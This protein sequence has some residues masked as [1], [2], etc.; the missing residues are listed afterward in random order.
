MLTRPDRAREETFHSFPEGLPGGQAVLYTVMPTTGGPDA[1]SL[2]VLDLRSGRTTI[3]LRGG[4]R[5]QYAPSGHLVY[6]AAGT[7]R[8]VRF[9]ATR[10]IVGGT[11]SLRCSPSRST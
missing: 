2:A 8:A 4:S 11:A 6:A 5:A 10:L 7:L 9:D 1:A 3:L